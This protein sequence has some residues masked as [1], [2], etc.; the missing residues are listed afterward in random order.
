MSP[1]RCGDTSDDEAH[2]LLS[3]LALAGPPPTHA[4]FSSLEKLDILMRRFV[5]CFPVDHPQHSRIQG[6][7]MSFYKKVASISS[8]P[9]SLTIRVPFHPSLSVGF[10]RRHVMRILQSQGR[11]LLDMA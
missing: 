9:C 8:F 11:L 4:W 7:L 5:Q 1:F 3:R 2:V 10:V 6:R